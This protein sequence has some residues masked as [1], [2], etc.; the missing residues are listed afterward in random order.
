M[1]LIIESQ[2]NLCKYLYTDKRNKNVIP[3]IDV[4]DIIF[5]DG[6]DKVE[7][8]NSYSTSISNIANMADNLPDDVTHCVSSLDNIHISNQD[9]IDVT[10]SLQ[11]KACVFDQ[12]SHILLKESLTI[13]TDYHHKVERLLVCVEGR[14]RI[15]QSGPIQD[16]KIGSCVLQC[17]VTHQWISQRQV[18]PVSVYCDVVRCHVLCLWHDILVWQYIGQSTTATSRH[19]RDMTSDRAGSRPMQSMQMHRSE[20]NCRCIHRSDFYRK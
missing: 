5:I 6:I 2:Q 11:S 20:K 19:R 14:G 13:S 4:Y 1:T 17:D 15:F 7:A 9:V 12:I 10:K 3:P 16:I 8:F 18:G